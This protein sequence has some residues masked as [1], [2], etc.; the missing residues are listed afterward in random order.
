[1]FDVIIDCENIFVGIY[2]MEPDGRTLENQQNYIRDRAGA[3]ARRNGQ[4]HTA[5]DSP[6]LP[7]SFESVDRD[8]RDVALD[9]AAT[10]SLA[11]EKMPLDDTNGLLF[12]IASGDIDESV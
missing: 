3:Q 5:A 7:F 1:M 12:A 9:V 6:F 10:A 4:V 11:H 8:G 2:R